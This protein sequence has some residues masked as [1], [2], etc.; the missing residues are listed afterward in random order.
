[1]ILDRNKRTINGKQV[2]YVFFDE[3]GHPYYL[4]GDTFLLDAILTSDPE[5]LAQIALTKESNTR[6]SRKNRHAPGTGELKHA[7]SNRTVCNQVMSEVREQDL[8]KFSAVCDT[9]DPI[10]WRPEMSERN[11]LEA[12]ARIMRMIAEYGPSGIYKIR[13]DHSYNYDPIIY[14]YVAEEAFLGTDK[15]LSF[16]NPIMSQD[17]EL[18]PALQTTDMFVGEHA[19]AIK[20]GQRERFERE[21]EIISCNR[22]GGRSRLPGRHRIQNRMNGCSQECMTSLALNRTNGFVLDAPSASP[23]SPSVRPDVMQ[24][25]ATIDNRIRSR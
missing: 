9:S 10:R 3:S 4:D 16:G 20:K 22:R 13:I 21:N 2:H 19:R 6:D 1:M 8:M 11:Y 24:P 14:K 7:R 17:S 23:R 12:Y 5:K 15:E 25:V 18:V